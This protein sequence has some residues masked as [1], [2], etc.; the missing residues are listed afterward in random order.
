MGKV[1]STQGPGKVAEGVPAQGSYFRF[2]SRVLHFS[3]GEGYQ[4]AFWPMCR[5]YYDGFGDFRSRYKAK[6]DKDAYQG[7]VVQLGG[8]TTD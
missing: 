4:S 2:Q 8:E 7:P 3:H 1:P 6:Y 5:D